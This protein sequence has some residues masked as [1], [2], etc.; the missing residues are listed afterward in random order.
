MVVVVER[1][2]LKE[3]EEYCPKCKGRPNVERVGDF[4]I[5]GTCL[6]CKGRG[7]VDWIDYAMNK[8]APLRKLKA[9][10]TMELQEDLKALHGLGTDEELA[11]ILADEI[12]EGINEIGKG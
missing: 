10:W 6:H 2:K 3:G 5:E 9:N 1:V 11:N 8:E 12:M 4:K 7:K